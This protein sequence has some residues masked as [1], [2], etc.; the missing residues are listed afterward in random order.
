MSSLCATLF[1]HLRKPFAFLQRRPEETTVTRSNLITCITA[2]VLLALSASGGS[3]AAATIDGG[4][5]RVASASYAIDGSVGDIAGTATAAPSA[6]RHGYIGQLT[7]VVSIT[8]TASPISV[9]EGST[10]QLSATATMDDSTVTALSSPDINWSIVSGPIL[11][12]DAAGMVTTDIVYTNSSASARGGYL[13]LT[14][15][16]TLDVLD[17]N[18]DNF[19]SYAGDGLPDSWQIQYFGF[20]NPNAGPTVDVCGTGQNNLFKYV[21]DLDP[22]NSASVFV[23]QIQSA[24]GQPNQT[25]LIFNPRYADRTYTPEF[26]T[27]LLTGTYEALT[28]AATSDNSLTRTVTDTNAVEASKFY[29]IRITY[30]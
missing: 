24:A 7:E 1:G 30:P 17:S 14:D 22:T 5:Q 25:R 23:L 4:G 26:R 12:I 18:P 3:V 13:G 6:A 29:R 16:V 9:D 15:T 8:V 2:P 21:A 27:N 10:S 11:S 20:N 28:S 19:G